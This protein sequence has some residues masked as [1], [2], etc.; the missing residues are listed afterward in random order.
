MEATFIVNML[1]DVIIIITTIAFITTTISVATS[2]NIQIGGGC[3]EIE[4]FV[5][6][7]CLSQCHIYLPIWI[8]EWIYRILLSLID[9]SSTPTEQGSENLMPMSMGVNKALNQ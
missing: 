1:I 9:I 2:F 4:Q 6:N 7:K 3:L 8:L 5:L